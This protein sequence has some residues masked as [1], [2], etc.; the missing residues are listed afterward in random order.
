MTPIGFIYLTTNLINGKIYVGK[1]EFKNKVK[2]YIGSGT[3]FTRAV[4]KYGK[5]NFKRK[6]LRLCYTLH[7]LRIWEHVY[8][9]KYK[10]YIRSIG[11]NIAKGDVNTSEYN[12]A[13]IVEV[14]KKISDGQLKYWKEHPEAKEKLSLRRKG[15]KASNETKK[16][17]SD[18]LKKVK[19]TEEWKRKISEA[20]SGKRHWAYGKTFTK[21][22]LADIFQVSPEHI[23]VTSYTSSGYVE[24][25]MINQKTYTGREMR[26]KLSLASSCFEIKFSS[27]GY[28][29]ITKGNGHG[30]GMSQYG[31]QAMALENKNYQ[32]ILHHYYQNIQIES[33]DS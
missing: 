15:A 13:T 20:N 25:V 22:Q 33:I 17:L 16:K 14:R 5:E 6:I 21:E 18:S 19:R 8:I 26:E 27:K 2:N 12:P 32:D 24:K 9:V 11:Y 10:S 28:T 3:Y 1:H 4:K 23:E 31:A 30:V 29:F 7:E